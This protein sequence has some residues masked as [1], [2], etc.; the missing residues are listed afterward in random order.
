MQQTED[1]ELVKRVLA[2]EQAAFD[3]FFDAY[4]S[5][6]CR[7]CTAR[8]QD[9]DAVEDIVQ[10]AMVKALRSLHT[11]RGEALLFSWMCQICRNEINTWFSRHGRRQERVVSID[12]NPSVRAALE[13]LGAELQRQHDQAIDLKELVQLTLDYLPVK[14]GKALELKYLEGFSVAEI[15]ERMG[16]GRLATQSLLARARNAFRDSFRDLQQELQVPPMVK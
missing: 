4:F 1:I 12:D 11:Y 3:E 6:L 7:F 2:K 9:V 14:Y 5:R 8:V 16:M 15:A 10:E 13:S